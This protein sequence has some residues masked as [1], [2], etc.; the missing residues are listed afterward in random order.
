MSAANRSRVR[1]GKRRR[2]RQ[3]KNGTIAMIARGK[4]YLPEELDRNAV[5]V[6]SKEVKVQER[7]YY[8]I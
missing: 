8:H 4:K 6:K 5:I 2:S 7:F 1:T 3:S